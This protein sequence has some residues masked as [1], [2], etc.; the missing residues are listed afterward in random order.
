[1]QHQFMHLNDYSDL[2][3]QSVICGFGQPQ[4]TVLSR[5]MLFMSCTKPQGSA[6]VPSWGHLDNYSF[7]L[8]SDGVFCY[9]DAL[10]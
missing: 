1:M 2:Q 4:C 8:Y 7:F 3:V 6:M 9:F 10:I 5:L